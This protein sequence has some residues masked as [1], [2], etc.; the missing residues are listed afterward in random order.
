MLLLSSDFTP[1]P[2]FAT[3]PIYHFLPTIQW[4]TN[5]MPS[6]DGSTYGMD[7]TEHG[8]DVHPNGK[9][10]YLN[11]LQHEHIEDLDPP[12]THVQVGPKITACLNTS[13][14]RGN[15]P[16]QNL[17]ARHQKYLQTASFCTASRPVLWDLRFLFEMLLSEFLPS[18]SFSLMYKNMHRIF[19]L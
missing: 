12:S 16:Y 9:R 19:Q 1:P 13:V 17:L 3:T 5:N 11:N 15:F 14:K 7:G 6:A 2:F 8:R 18:V 10:F 4:E